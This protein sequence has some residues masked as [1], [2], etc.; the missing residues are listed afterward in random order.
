[1]RCLNSSCGFE[2]PAGVKFCPECGTK[3]PPP[4]P[5]GEVGRQA[6]G[7]S[8]GDKNVVGGDLVGSKHE[9]KVLGGSYTNITHS[10][11]TRKTRKCAISGR[12]GAVT[13]GHEC[14]ACDRW[15]VAEFF[16]V[17]VHRCKE[18]EAEK[19][20]EAERQYDAK[21]REVYADSRVDDAER[22]ELRDLA[23]RLGMAEARTQ[24]MERAY[25][26]SGQSLIDG[27]DL[28]RL[29]QAE[30]MLYADFKVDEAH[31][32]IQALFDVYGRKDRRLWELYM[33]S[34]TEF[35]PEAALQLFESLDVDDAQA[36]L[37]RIELKVR[38]GDLVGAGKLIKEARQK[39]PGLPDWPL[40]EAETLMEEYRKD[41]DHQVFL[42]EAARKIDPKSLAEDWQ[43]VAAKLALLK[44]GQ[45]DALNR[46]KEKLTFGT[47]GYFRVVRAQKYFMTGPLKLCM[48]GHEYACRSGDV[49][50]RHGTVAPNVMSAINTLSRRH[51]QVLLRAGAWHM[52]VLSTTNVSTLDGKPM[53]AGRFYP[54]Q[55][56]QT[57]KLS[58]QCEFELRTKLQT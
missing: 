35:D 51:A 38:Q 37:H 48:G 28:I 26:E 14:P 46:L 30:K 44:D 18:C 45:R 13:D 16:I 22:R 56:E 7:I 50:G 47:L 20:A 3:I 36:Y 49:I 53:E 34:L 4:P 5:P 24:E 12:I 57:I 42:E 10:D 52:K 43:W 27:T 40:M 2:V 58:S 1:M 23:E 11:E 39:F 9:V 6:S 55:L 31:A 21:L 33:T 29:G 8:L 25:R 19:R 15:V 32:R 17:S 54:L 41:R